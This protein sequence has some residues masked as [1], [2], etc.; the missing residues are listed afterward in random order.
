MEA[1]KRVRRT[2]RSDAVAME[3]SLAGVLAV[4]RAQ[5]RI[6]ALPHVPLLLTDFL[7]D[8]RGK[9]VETANKTGLT[10][11]LR[12]LLKRCDLPGAPEICR[13]L[14]FLLGITDASV[15]GNIGSLEV[16]LAYFPSADSVIIKKVYEIAIR[17]GHVHLLEWLHA[18]KAL[19]Y[20]EC[21]KTLITSFTY[22][23]PCVVY[24][25]HA[26]F[27]ALRLSISVE[28][29]A[30]RSSEE[31]SLEFLEWLW[32]RKRGFH[33]DSRSVAQTIAATRRF[34]HVKMAV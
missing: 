3:W 20:D 18:L 30:K 5:Q 32:D 8:G 22:S 13:R 1:N 19:V 23:R 7:L 28:N 24:W 33:I 6:L 27:P 2:E 11:T 9:K 26:H 17:M 15:Q 12:L 31:G 16:W 21:T 25:L 4:C 10:H 29:V 34:V 14:R